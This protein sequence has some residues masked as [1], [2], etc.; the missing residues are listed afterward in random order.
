MYFPFLRSKQFELIALREISD[1]LNSGRVIHPVI[2][3]VK[4]NPSSIKKTAEILSN[5]DILF[6]LI[7]NP[8]VGDLKNNLNH[9]LTQLEPI[10]N[11]RF[12]IGINITSSFNQDF[13][14]V[15]LGNYQEKDLT[16]IHELRYHD[17]PGLQNYFS[18]R[19]IQYNLYDPNIVVPSRYLSLIPVGTRVK[20]TDPFDK[21]LRNSDY[22][23]DEYLFSD[24]Y[25]YFRAD[26][27]DGF[28]DFQTIGSDYLDQGFAPKAV[29]IHLT[30]VKNDAIW[31]KHF[32]SDSNTDIS[33]VAGKFGEAL[34]KLVQFANTQQLDTR[35]VHTFRELARNNLY[36]GLG[37]IKKLSI[38]NHIEVIYNEL[39][40]L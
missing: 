40:I 39:N 17:L 3:L 7:V 6:T 1:L 20:L 38:M 18:G 14:T 5:N 30:Y 15:V 11:L 26:G 2:E 37:T 4:D 8:S 25:K 29:A 28:S 9:I 27:F 36:P 21:A 13:T 22:V 19:R 34:S 23:E 16:L 32:V 10:R 24:D 33:D 12:N 31:I 35:A